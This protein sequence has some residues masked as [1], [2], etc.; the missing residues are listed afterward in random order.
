MYRAWGYPILPIIF[1]VSTAII[2]INELS[3]N[4]RERI[5]GLAIVLAG[6]PLYYLRVARLR[7]SRASTNADH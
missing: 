6:L 1:I 7:Q 4:P 2:V 5:T 3:T